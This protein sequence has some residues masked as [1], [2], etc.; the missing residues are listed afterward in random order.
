MRPTQK[1][2]TSTSIGLERTPHSPLR[3]R[4]TSYRDMCIAENQAARCPLWVK[5]RHRRAFG[6][7]PLYP[8][9]QTSLAAMVMSALCQK[10]T[11][12]VQLNNRLFDH[13]IGKG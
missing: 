4:V 8:Q 2:R 7:C 1:T 9:K 11:Y 12:A 6:R 13:P 10:R 3:S 5:R